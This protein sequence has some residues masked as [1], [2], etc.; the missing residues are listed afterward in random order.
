MEKDTVTFNVI[1]E[2]WVHHGYCYRNL[3]PDQFFTDPEQR[4]QSD[5]RPDPS[6]SVT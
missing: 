5:R 4:F 6:K 3:N 2:P 1:K